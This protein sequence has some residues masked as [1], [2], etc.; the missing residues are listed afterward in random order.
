MRRLIAAKKCPTIVYVS[1]TKRT[2]VLADRLTSDGFKALPYNGKM[3]PNEK[4]ANQDAFMNGEVSIIVA[5]TAFGM[6]VNKK[7][8]GLVIHYDISDSLENYMQEA[9]RAGRDPSLQADCYILFNDNDLDQHFIQLNQD[10]LSICQI[11]QVWKAI[12][13][14]TQNRMTICCSALELARQAGWDDSAGSEIETRIRTALAALENAG[15]I[16]RGNNCPRVFATSIQAKSMIEAS[17]RI[18][19][20][21]LFSDEQKETAISIMHDLIQKRSYATGDN[22]D[23]E[24]RVD[25]LADKKGLSK[26][27]VIELITLMRQEGLLEDSCDMSAYIYGTDTQHKSM[28]VLDRF[29]KLERFILSK[30]EEE[31]GQFRYKKLNEEAE[32][33]GITTSTVKNIR[34]LLFFLSIKK[35]ISKEE[36]RANDSVKIIPELD[37]D[38][39]KEKF[40]RRIELCAFILG[41]L[42]AKAKNNAANREEDDIRPVEFS[43]V[44]LFKAYQSTPR[45]NLGG[46]PA[47]LGDVEDALLYLS[48]IG[49]LKLE[50]GF[51]VLYNGMEIKRIV[52]DNRIKYKM[53]DYRMLDEFYDQ[54]IR[55]IH[56]VGEY[57]NMMM[58]DYNSALQFVRD[59]FTMESSRFISKYFKGAREKEINRNITP[60]KYKQLFGDLSAIQEKIIGDVSKY[61]VV[62]A[63]PGSGKTRV[64]VHKL[65][66]LYQL[67]DVKHEQMLMLTFSRAAATEFK[68]RLQ[69]LIGNVAHYIEIKTFHSYCFDLLGRIGSLETAENIVATAA[70]KIFRGDVEQG[71]ITKTVLV[72][73]EAQDM[74]DSEFA[75]VRALMSVNEDMRIIAVGDDDQ[76]IYQF[77]ESHSRHL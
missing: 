29:A 75:L 52:R 32:E 62:A 20:S 39:L 64:L 22:D 28:L 42:Y 21:S 23:A 68:K 41:E 15:Y 44:G 71:K 3:D 10:K 61:I 56:I 37:I 36:N 30:I 43:L 51:L 5:T 57:A 25:Y 11:Q 38:L 70:E 17:R 73:D 55:Q 49:A 35:Y 47:V 4:I 45:M 40:E 48:K 66:S 63:G 7:D 13:D 1:R 76:N 59:Y 50:G 31:G 69:S 27:T 67:E 34:T 65:A 9:G 14:L 60:A 24:S 53:D 6:G 33:A 19:N 18:R 54:R 77:R 12:K 58:R 46:A 74:D 8:V 2:R 26:E 16:V 72:I